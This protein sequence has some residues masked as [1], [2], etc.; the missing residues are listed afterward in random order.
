LLISCGFG[1]EV[2][3]SDSPQER[4]GLLNRHT[5]DAPTLR[6]GRIAGPD[7]AAV[8]SVDRHVTLFLFERKVQ[9]AK[10]KTHKAAL[11]D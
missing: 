1:S 11:N 6:H 2:R 8:D 4:C 7:V 9:N 3:I 5:S 10:F